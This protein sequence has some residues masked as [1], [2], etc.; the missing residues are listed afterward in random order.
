MVDVPEVPR[1][2]SRRGRWLASQRA[3]QARGIWSERVE[4]FKFAPIAPGA[5]GSTVPEAYTV[6]SLGGR[7]VRMLAFRGTTGSNFPTPNGFELAN[8]ALRVL[9][10]GQNDLI[11]GPD[12]NAASFAML[13][14]S[15]EAP[16]FWFL[17]PPVLRTGDRL[18]L[19]VANSDSDSTLS[20]EVGLRLMDDTLWQELYTRDWRAER[21]A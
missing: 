7:Y 13:F 21:T 5:V 12:G 4:D 1:R 8:L 20:P 3:D 19:T 9:L 10:N 11:V 15:V 14:D 6:P 2:F 18:N 17:S 16:W